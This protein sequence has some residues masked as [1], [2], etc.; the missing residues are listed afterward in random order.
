MYVCMHANARACVCV[1]TCVWVNIEP[2]E[3]IKSPRVRAIGGCHLPVLGNKLES[4]S[5]TICALSHW[6][7]SP[8][9]EQ[10][11]VIDLSFPIS[12]V[13][14]LILYGGIT[15]YTAIDCFNNVSD[16]MW[17]GRG[18]FEWVCLPGCLSG[19]LFIMTE[20]CSSSLGNISFI[21]IRAA[22]VT[23]KQVSKIATL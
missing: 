19:K 5:I 2:E 15:Y 3:A 8:A 22:L 10:Y 17:T 11:I 21:K 12:V 4:S 23:L 6:A 1:V 18:K 20:G 7:I 13:K 16:V 9:P 14:R